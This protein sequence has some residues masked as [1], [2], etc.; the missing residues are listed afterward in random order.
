MRFCV[1]SQET[2]APSL[3]SH[4]WRFFSNFLCCVSAVKVRDYHRVN[5]WVSKWMTSDYRHFHADRLV[6][7]PSPSLSP[8]GSHDALSQTLLINW[9]TFTHINLLCSQG[10]HKHHLQTSFWYVDEFCISSLLRSLDLAIPSMKLSVMRTSLWENF[11]FD[12]SAS[13]GDMLKRGL[14]ASEHLLWSPGGPQALGSLAIHGWHSVHTHGA[15]LQFL[16][17]I[18]YFAK[19]GVYHWSLQWGCPLEETD[20]LKAS[21]VLR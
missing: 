17:R 10:W 2:S 15:A 7:A 3:D 11:S 1:K 8:W 19:H 12:H 14:T 20:S 18:S 4:P 9:S 13:P 16:L 6:R 21:M 5:S